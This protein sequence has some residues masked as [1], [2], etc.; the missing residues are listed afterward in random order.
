MIGC[1]KMTEWKDI[2]GYEGLYRVSTSGEVYSMQSK[3]NLKQF[4][5]GSREDNKY[6]VVDLHKNKKGKTISVH[7]IVAEA[8]IPNTNDLP[9]V[10][11]KD[12]NKDNNCVDNLEWCTYSENNYHACRTGLKSIPSGTKNKCSKLTYDD[13]VAIKKCLIL[14][15][16]K[17]GTRPLS[18][19]YGVDHKVI[20]DIYHNRKYQDV[21]IPYTF[22]VSSDIHSAYTPW[23]K[24]LKQTGFNE[25]KYSHKL[26]VC[27]DV[28]D[29]MDESVEVLSF[30]MRMVEKDKII[31]I[32]GNH[33]ILLEEL[34]MREFPYSHDS[35]NGTKKTVQ[36][37]GGAGYGFPF[38]ECCRITWNKT[39]AYRDLLVNYFETQNYIFVHS[40][41][42]TNIQ[43]EGNMKPWYQQGKTLTWME[44]W[45]NANDVEWEEAM[46]GNPFIRAE[47]D[48]NKTG[49][50]IVFGHWHCSA[51]HKILG[52]CNDEFDYAIWEPCYFK[53]TIGID[54]CTAHTGEVNVLV[55][56][57]EFLA[58]K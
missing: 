2:I 12:G 6:L 51:G 52:N 32:K 55:I 23:M 41:I 7:R 42:P 8:F 43:Y 57:D 3:K 49:K 45:R 58:D 13:V 53:N 20:M 25:N 56:E 22:F 44:D 19:Q 15:D 54:R 26:I 11:H 40:W 33:D 18:K 50:T 1:D 17:Y 39:A 31:L 9:C 4:Y 35:H 48:L 14:G 37:L 28:F 47:Q 36:D 46:W 38:D 21:K 29:R 5:R 34:C 30:I 10:N 27:G 24:A 16:S